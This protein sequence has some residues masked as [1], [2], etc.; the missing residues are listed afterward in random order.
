MKLKFNLIDYLIII[1]VIIA[2][3]FAFIHITTSDSDDL[4]KTAFDESTFNKI[5]DTYLKY[6]KDGFI[7]NATIDG[8]NATNGEKITLSG[9]II[10]LDA[11]GGS[12]VKILINSNNT[13]YLTGL[14]RYIP[15]ADVYIDH[16][17]LESN[18]DKYKNL[19]EITIKSKKIKTLNDLVSGINNDTNFE[20]TT[21]VSYDLINSVEIQE[22]TNKLEQDSKRPSIK[23]PTSDM[24]NQ[25]VIS[26]ATRQ[27]INDASSILGDADGIT[28]SIVIR[29]YNCS[30]QDIESIKQHFDVINI[31]NFEVV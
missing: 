24:E 2:V 31:R 28:S 21:K 8:F 6:Y 18:G 11:D 4:Q 10:W 14:Y 9:N 25:I 29:V 12:D 16:I 17:S 5:T 13:T 22:V 3:I 7:V 30:N 26:K 15:N 20:I 1:I 19:S 23:I 27:N